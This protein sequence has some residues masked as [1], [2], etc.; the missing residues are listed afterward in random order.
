LLKSIVYIA[1]LFAPFASIGQLVTNGGQSPMQLVQNVLLGPGVTVSNIVY[2]GSGGAIGSFAA[3]GTNLGINSGIVLTTGTI[4]NTGQGPQGPNN[5][6]NA[7]INN[8][9]PG[10]GIFNQILATGTPTFNASILE[11]DFVPYSDTVRFKYVFG[12]EEYP[13]YVGEP[14]ND[15]FGF[16]ISGP[17]IIGTQNIAKVPGGGGEI[18]INNVNNGNTN[19]GPCQNCNYY[20]YNG[21]GN[22]GPYNSSTNYIQYDGFTKVMEAVSKVQ[23]GQTYHLV[24]AVADVFDAIYDSGIFLEANSLSSKT[25]VE[26]SY[27]LSYVAFPSEPKVLAE[28][29]VSSTITLSRQGN[30]SSALT[31]PLTVTGT[32]TPGVDF[33]SIPA[34][35]TFAPNQ[36]TTSFTFSAL[37]DG[38]VE[39]LET[40]ILNFLLTDPCGNQTPLILGLGIQDIAPV[41]LNL[42]DTT[43]LCSGD[44]VTL[45]SYPSGGVGPY[46]YAWNTGETSK[47][48]VVNP[49]TTTNYSLMI[50]DNCLVESASAN[51]TVTVPVYQPIALTITPDITEICP[52]LK[53]TLK[54]VATGGTGVYTYNWKKVGGSNIGNGSSL[55]IQPSLTTTYRVI[56]SDQ[57][58]LIDS[59]DVVYTILSPPLL[60]TMSP[61][62]TICPGEDAFLSV[63]ASGGF[64]AYYYEWIQ[65]SQTTPN[66]T[67][68]PYSTTNYTVHVSDDCQTFFVQGIA[69]VKV[70]KP[71][72]EFIVSS[73]T[74]MEGLPITFQNLTLNGVSYYWEFGDGNTSTLIHP[75]N[76]YAE[77]GYYDVWLIATDSNGCIDSTK[78]G[79]RILEET[80]LYVPNAFTPDEDRFNSVFRVEAIGMIKF[81][82][83]IY[84]RWG[85][86]IFESND[87]KFE[88]DGAVTDTR[89]GQ[90][91]VYTYLITYSTRYDIN[92]RKIGHINLLR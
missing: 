71:N 34:S 58:G 22:N 38:L 79:V 35:V 69:T 25:P 53:D 86:L 41:A 49:T 83:K 82:I 74:V 13:E 18:S 90:D 4:S 36:S 61:D 46:T 15:I 78:N 51:V 24:I 21:T 56:V 29:C 16:F 47:N 65:T 89:K 67:V 50:T 44:D 12:S 66:I 37:N 11:F 70:V 63:S 48:I 9:A 84:N 76:T 45:I 3:N 20:V 33:S 7:G 2:S 91:G 42:L 30:I 40:V 57:C 81:N 19:T 73:N 62:V 32:A 31:I 64:G 77:A 68:N 75:N 39:G 8:N 80:Y 23:C 5:K 55:L 27:S 92:Q 52:Y 26:L 17:G 60:I 10:T 6:D 87:D 72:A 59:A 14:F 88:W 85:E 54:V 43:V 28:G 1:F